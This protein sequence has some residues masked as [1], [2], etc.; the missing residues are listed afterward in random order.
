MCR[1]AT[2]YLIAMIQ[3]ISH[4][5]QTQINRDNTLENKHRFEYDYKV[6]YKIILTRHTAYK[7]KI[8]YNGPFVR[9]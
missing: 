6:V 4:L 8:P 5:K 3:T 1:E 7:Y 9:K 2:K